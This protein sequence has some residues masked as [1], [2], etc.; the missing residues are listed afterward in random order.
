M[1][2]G[3]HKKR[4]RKIWYATDFLWSSSLLL[5]FRFSQV[6]VVVIIIGYRILHRVIIVFGRRM[7]LLMMFG[8]RREIWWFRQRW[9]HAIPIFIIWYFDCFCFDNC[10]VEI[11]FKI[12]LSLIVYGMVQLWWSFSN[13]AHTRSINK[14]DV[15]FLSILV[16]Q[17][18]FLFT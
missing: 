11:F 4:W 10:F 16:I 12:F 8:L 5:L 14:F 7:L 3:I 15:M 2:Y 1:K 6:V 13:R 9:R 18:F 17:S